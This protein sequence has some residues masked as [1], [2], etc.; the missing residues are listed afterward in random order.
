[1]N[2]IKW[3]YWLGYLLVYILSYMYLAFYHKTINLSGVI[4]HESGALNFTEA[5]FYSSHF[6]AHIPVHI[7]LILVF[8][9]CIILFS[10][11]SIVFKASL[12]QLVFILLLFLTATLV[13]SLLVFGAEDTFEYILQKKQ[14]HNI[15]GEGGSWKLHLASTISLLFLIPPY[16]FVFLSLLG[17]KTGWNRKGFFFISAGLVLIPVFSIL[18]DGNF[19]SGLS[20]AFTS[21]R[22][23]AHSVRELI[24]FPLTYFPLFF[25]VS[26][27]FNNFSFRINKQILNPAKAFILISTIIFLILF[28]YQTVLPLKEGIGNLSQKPDFT[29]GESLPLLYLI[30]SHYFEHFLDTLFFVLSALIILK[31]K[32]S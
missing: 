8:A 5:M 29:R 32:E 10:D 11:G 19:F 30:T 22:Y 18:C 15:Y 16:T 21:N 27:N 12:K 2:R 13:H 4:I 23:L 3:K 20:Q 28:A 31:W 14:G 7:V 17:L 26:Y 9:G 25:L 24:T 6:L 1:M